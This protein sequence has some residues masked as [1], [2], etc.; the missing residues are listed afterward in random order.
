MSLREFIRRVRRIA[1]Y[2]W[3]SKSW[4]F[5]V[6]AV[7]FW[8]LGFYPIQYSFKYCM[9][10]LGSVYPLVGGWALSKRYCAIYSRRGR[11]RFRRAFK[12]LTMAIPICIR[13]TTIPPEWRRLIGAS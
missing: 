11:A 1:P 8:S 7:S 6:L 10:S 2:L 9:P 12:P 13:G 3:P 5:Q 4:K